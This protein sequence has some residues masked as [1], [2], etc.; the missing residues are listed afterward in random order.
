MF[1]VILFV[2]G[3]EGITEVDMPGEMSKQTAPKTRETESKSELQNR[4]GWKSLYESFPTKEQKE[5]TFRRLTI[6]VEVEEI[7]SRW[8]ST[9]E[10]LP[11]TLRG[12]PEVWKALR[13]GDM[14][15]F[16][17]ELVRQESIEQQKHW[18][19]A[20]TMPPKERRER[21]TVGP[22]Q[23]TTSK[24]ERCKA[25]IGPSS[26]R[27]HP[28]SC[29]S[30]AM[31]THFPHICWWIFCTVPSP[32]TLNDNQ[33]EQGIRVIRY[34]SNHTAASIQVQFYW[35]GAIKE[36]ALAT[37]G[38]VRSALTRLMASCFEARISLLGGLFRNPLEPG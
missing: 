38:F 29:F 20:L 17:L 25:S 15:L 32:L 3:G 36:V 18:E 28:A 22:V 21:F 8:R 26:E 4:W 6:V 24:I 2:L 34:S 11:N 27:E 10:R 13:V 19:F 5:N 7:T 35:C 1:H 33:S 14:A 12:I 23:Q 30:F 37:R 16:F 9:V 31:L